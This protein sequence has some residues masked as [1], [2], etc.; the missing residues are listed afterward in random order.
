MMSVVAII[1]KISN[2]NIRSVIADEANDLSTFEPLF[3]AIIL[4]FEVYFCTG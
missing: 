3:I 4:G 2:K 1:I